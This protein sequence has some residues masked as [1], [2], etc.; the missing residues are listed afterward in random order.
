[1]EKNIFLI[2]PEKKSLLQKDKPLLIKLI[3]HLFLN[4]QDQYMKLK[5]TILSL[6][7]IILSG[8]QEKL[9]GDSDEAFLASRIKIEENLTTTEKENLEKAFRVIAGYAMAEKWKNP[10]AYEGK[11]FND[12]TLEIVNNK[13]YK[14]VI[15]FAENYLKKENEEKIDQLKIEIDEL[16]IQRRKA[17]SVISVLN[18]FKTNKVY[19]DIGSWDQP[20]VYVEVL[21]TG[22]LS[23]II[24]YMFNLSIYSI[25]QNKKIDAVGIGGNYD[26][27]ESV[28]ENNFFTYVSRSLST[29]MERSKKLEN[30]LKDAQYPIT[31]IKKYDL[32]VE[33]TPSKIILNDGT[34]LL[35]PE[36]NLAYFDAEIDALNKQI[37][38]FK[39]LNGSLDELELE[40]NIT[41]DEPAFNEE[42]LDTLNEIRKNNK[43]SLSKMFRVNTDLILTFPVNYKIIKQKSAGMYSYSLSDSL[44]FD[45]SDKNLI[46]YQIIDSTYTEYKSSSDKA[47]GQLNILKDKNI[48]YDIKETIKELKSTKYYKLV[49]ADDSGYI[50]ISG[51]SY[52]LIRYFKAN[53][54]HYLYTMEFKDLSEGVL[55]FDRS[56]GIIK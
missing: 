51:D 49:D 2:E 45:N 42:F 56:K 18:V 22:K 3:T 29:I 39:T 41:K 21:K 43:Q 47:N 26:K 9:S 25:A 20:T 5:F 14:N 1:M 48:E 33:V 31:D 4:Y 8:C 10:E 13:T 19:I 32:R 30:Q 38:E 24:E 44:V 37:A 40:E 28:N 11:S 46:Q 12:I 55:E 52:N 54:Y 23:G 53:H 35:Y 34:T 50:Y 16:Q 6:L 15:N 7:I 36:K 17:D 27:D